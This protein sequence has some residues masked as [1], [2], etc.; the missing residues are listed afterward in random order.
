MGRFIN[1]SCEPNCIIEIWSSGGCLKVGYLPLSAVLLLICADI[2]CRLNHLSSTLSSCHHRFPLSCLSG[3]H[4]HIS[5]HRGG[6]RAYLRL[7][8]ATQRP[9]PYHMPLRHTQLS[10]HVRGIPQTVL[11]LRSRQGTGTV[12]LVRFGLSQQPTAVSR[13]GTTQVCISKNTCIVP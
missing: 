3:G 8:M 6:G 4:L 1:H 5:S 12:L 2:P 7:P 9:S 10:R 13:H 11:L